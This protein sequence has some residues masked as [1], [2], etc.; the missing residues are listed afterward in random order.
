[1][2][3]IL[4]G[5]MI[6]KEIKERI[7]EEV[8]RLE[9]KPKLVVI[10]VGD[11]DASKIYVRNKIK[12]CENVGIATEDYIL[13]KDT[14]EKELVDLIEK[15]NKNKEVN[16]ILVQLPLP[17]HLNE[18]TI[19]NT[20]SPIKDVDGLNIINQGNLLNRKPVLVPATPKGIIT[21]L[22]RYFV[23][24][25]GK[26]VVIVGR[27]KLVGMP[28]ALLFNHANATVTICHSYTED[29]KDITKQA[30]IL[31]SAVGKADFISGD[32]IKK[33]AVVV[34]VGINRQMGHIVGDV[35]FKEAMEVARLV[36]PVPKGVG[37]MTIASLLENVLEC[38][39]LQKR[40]M[41]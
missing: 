5:Q 40:D 29:L 21:L 41:K 30:D 23:E 27:S 20:I 1:M 6:S 26:R 13:P 24:I 14:R 4:D 34:D 25:E 38:Y 39:D 9:V 8:N 15:L 18:D 10:L 37:P 33:D 19:V 17:R 12:A 11:D 7:K 28:L 31:V 22:K 3:Q 35:N 16:G 32:M 2:S 36:T